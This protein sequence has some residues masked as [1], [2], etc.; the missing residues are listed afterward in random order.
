MTDQLQTLA[1]LLEYPTG[2][3][4][5]AFAPALAA[6]SQDEREELYTGTFDVTPACVPYVSIHLFGEE[7][8]KRGEFMAALSARY[9]AAGFETR[10][11]LPDH[12]AVL[13]RFLAQTDEAERRELVQFCLLGPLGKMIAALSDENPYRALLKAVREVLAAAYPDLQPAVSPLEQMQ[14]HGAVCV[15]AD[16]GCG[17]CGSFTNHESRVTNHVSRYD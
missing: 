13:L 12:L 9:A 4:Y 6:L 15:T 7:N 14:S 16:T 2:Q 11:E 5:A 3:D 17:G 1:R 8:F 10:G